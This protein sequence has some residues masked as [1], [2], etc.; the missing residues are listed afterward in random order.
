MVL[1]VALGKLLDCIN[2]GERPT[3][4]VVEEVVVVVVN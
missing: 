3:N 2:V 1:T 4:A